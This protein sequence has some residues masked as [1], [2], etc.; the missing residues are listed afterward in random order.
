MP[1]TLLRALHE[2]PTQPGMNIGYLSFNHTKEPWKSNLH[3]RKAIA[4]AINRKA[5]VDNLYQGMG[6]VAKNPIP[7]TMWGYNEQVP[8]FKYDVELAKAVIEMDLDDSEHPANPMEVITSIEAED[9]KLK[10]STSITNLVELEKEQGEK[11]QHN[12]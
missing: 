7:P 6:Q 10:A 9:P 11:H 8:G 1:P 12:D 3:L 5:I 4:H 2:L